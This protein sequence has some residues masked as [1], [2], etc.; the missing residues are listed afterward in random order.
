MINKKYFIS[1]LIF[2]S[3]IF[4]FSNVLIERSEKS[5]PEWII[6]PP[7]NTYVGIYE[8]AD[9]LDEGISK[10][11]RNA[12]NYVMLNIGV[13]VSSELELETRVAGQDVIH[14]LSE[15]LESTGISEIRDQ[16][17]KNIYY[18]KFKGEN[19]TYSVFVLLHY[20]QQAIR[21]AREWI[22][23]E[24]KNI[25]SEW[26]INKNRV[27]QNLSK[28][29]I[30][31]AL[32]I[33]LTSLDRANKFG[34]DEVIYD[35]SS[36]FTSIWS[37]ISIQAYGAENNKIV[38][39]VVYDNGKDR[40]FVRSSILY[41]KFIRGSGI[42]PPFIVTNREGIAETTYS[43]IVFDS[44]N[45]AS[46][47]CGFNIESIPFLSKFSELVNVVRMKNV[48]FEIS[49]AKNRIIVL[50]FAP[51]DNSYN[52]KIFITSLYERIIT[53]FSI[54]T[55]ISIIDSGRAGIDINTNVAH[56]DL[57]NIFEQTDA[58][59]A[60]TGRVRN[61]DG[62]FEVNAR[63]TSRNNLEILSNI[64]VVSLKSD[65]IKVTKDI[66]QDFITKIIS[67]FVYITDL[68]ISPGQVSLKPGTTSYPLE[69]VR[70]HAIYSDGTEKL[71]PTVSWKIQAGEGE[72]RSNI[73]TIKPEAKELGLSATFS[74]NGF[75]AEKIFKVIIE[76][77][78][79]ITLE[80][81]LDTELF[82]TTSGDSKWFG[83]K[84]LSFDGFNSA[85][86]GQM[87]TGDSILE[88]V[89]NG[90]GILTFQWK[91]QA[92]TN[93]DVLLYYIDNQMRGALTGNSDWESK[94]YEITEG[95]HNIKWVFE[96]RSRA[97]SEKIYAL[98]DRL[99]F[100]PNKQSDSVLTWSVINRN[101]GFLRRNGFA[102][103]IFNNNIYIIGGQEG[104][105]RRRDIWISD[106][107]VNWKQH[108]SNAGFTGRFDHATSVFQNK[109]FL[110]AG[111]DHYNRHKNDVWVCSDG[112]NFNLLIENAQWSPRQ[113][114]SMFVFDNKL[115]IIGGK[116]SH[117]LL[118]D[119]WSSDDGYVWKQINAN[120]PFDKRAYHA[121]LAF[122]DRMVI[123]GGETQN[124]EKSDVW[125]S[126]DG[127]IWEN[128]TENAG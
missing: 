11:I 16:Q 56:I 123:I 53:E 15:K 38:A 121:G 99:I 19:V 86:S 70:V 24:T 57:N 69:N 68:R 6:R 5:R 60:I 88:A 39:R 120:P 30:I 112:R 50:P 14:E 31:E 43:D 25:R 106:N 113:G 108:N 62:N 103:E 2:V 40:F 10:A 65:S 58:D 101:A 90:P 78:A 17:I 63:L 55:D 8:K 72:I 122:K 127:R 26:T 51:S 35:S 64:T 46:V 21:E 126:K 109:I 45:S 28:G 1:L 9:T 29:E 48:S 66:F 44:K 22:E 79:V 18:E 34:V 76:R 75:G 12:L 105:N 54:P 118:N 107:G 52:T 36:L 124:G 83:Q 102:T 3:I 96:K 115:W 77:K 80:D 47:E 81:A 114:H 37:D 23:N 13:R 84:E 111:Y 7:Q 98:I 20:P 95:R 67:D 128:I 85:R 71:I 27:N 41:L 97:D 87:R 49:K 100:T 89:V 73:L 119:V 74:E 92:V 42:I 32:R 116:T 33:L 59:Y 94:T 104:R 61:V 93:S 110:S 125:V 82:I 4:T 91:T 117:G